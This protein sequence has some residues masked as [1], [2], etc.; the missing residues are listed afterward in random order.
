[1]VRFGRNLAFLREAEWRCANAALEQRLNQEMHDWMQST[2]GPPLGDT[3][4][5]RTAARE[6]AR[7]LGGRVLLNVSSSRSRAPEVYL[8]RRQ[9]ELDF[10]AKVLKLR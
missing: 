8:S 10:S 3:H 1:M 2:G 9:M 7:R 4:P 5:E 6:M